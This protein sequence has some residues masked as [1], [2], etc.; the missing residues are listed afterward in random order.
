M[1]QGPLPACHVTA[2]VTL[3]GSLADELRHPPPPLAR[4]P[5]AGLLFGK[6]SLG[7]WIMRDAFGPQGGI[8]I[9]IQAIMQELLKEGKNKGRKK[10]KFLSNC[11]SVRPFGNQIMLQ[12]HYKHEFKEKLSFI[13]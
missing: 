4:P 13:S 8:I 7:Q 2:A 6:C 1:A 9:K 11:W 10:C 5:P 3:K 12:I